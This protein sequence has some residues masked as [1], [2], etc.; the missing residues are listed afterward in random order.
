MER[1]I[2]DVLCRPEERVYGVFEECGVVS[3]YIE[4]NGDSTP[5]L[6]ILY[7]EQIFLE[8]WGV[9]LLLERGL[10]PSCRLHPTAKPVGFHLVLSIKP[11]SGVVA[12]FRYAIAGRRPAVGGG[13]ARVKYLGDNP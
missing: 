3:V 2:C 6:H 5:H 4:R 7:V 11:C 9:G 12:V 8:Y 13:D 10:I 1:V